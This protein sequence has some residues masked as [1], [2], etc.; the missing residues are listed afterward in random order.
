LYVEIFPGAGAGPIFETLSERLAAV[1]VEFGGIEVRSKAITPRRR[2]AP[3][4][5]KVLPTKK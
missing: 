2:A 5:S 1:T 3:G 4:F